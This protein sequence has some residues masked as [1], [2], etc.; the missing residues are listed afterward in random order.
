MSLAP[1]F[2]GPLA[3][4]IGRKWVLLS[5]SVFLILAFVLMMVAQR[6]WVLLLGR[7]L[8][9]FGAGFVMTITPMYVGE[10]STDNVRG[11]TGSLMQLFLVGKHLKGNIRYTSL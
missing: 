2:A 7:F 9:G 1:F 3:D 10:I 5:S 11:A 8:Q 6:V 4:K